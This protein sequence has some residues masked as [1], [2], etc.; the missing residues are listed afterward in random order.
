[1]RRL[2]LLLYARDLRLAWRRPV[3]AL[4]PFG[5]FIVAAAMFPL[6]IGPEPQTLRQIAPGLIWVCAL[7]ATATALA[8]RGVGVGRVHRVRAGILLVALLTVALGWWLERAIDERRGPR[9]DH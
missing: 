1:M 7:L 8:W 5:F 9:H 2:F 4:L 6:G 3:D